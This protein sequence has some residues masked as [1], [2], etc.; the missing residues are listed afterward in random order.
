MGD[1][2]DVVADGR[3]ELREDKSQ[4]VKFQG[5][6]GSGREEGFNGIGHRG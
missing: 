4:M 2:V 3:L 1:S 5:E 6:K